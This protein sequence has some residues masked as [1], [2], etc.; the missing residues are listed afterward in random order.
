MKRILE[1]VGPRRTDFLLALFCGVFLFLLEKKLPIAR[2]DW[3]VFDKFT[4]LTPSLRPLDPSLAIVAIDDYSIDLLDKSN[5]SWPWP[6]GAYADMIAYLKMAG[7]REIWIDM[8]LY[9]KDSDSLQDD[10]LRAVAMAAQNV[11]FGQ[12]KDSAGSVSIFKP[13]FDVSLPESDNAN[14]VI[15]YDNGGERLLA[16]PRPF[17]ELIRPPASCVTSAA[18]VVS[19][20]HKLLKILPPD[21]R[22]D[23]EK[24]ARLWKNVNY[25]LQSDPFRDKIVYIGATAQSTNDIKHFPVGGNEPGVMIHVVTRSNKLQN[26]FFSRE[27]YLVARIACGGLLFISKRTVHK[28][29]KFLSVYRLGAGYGGG[30]GSGFVWTV[31]RSNLVW[32]D[33]L[34]PIDCDNLYRGHLNQ[35]PER[36]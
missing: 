35:L 9:T 14:P 8:V 28:V 2:S 10:E 22:T 3:V 33:A 1:F 20:G 4:Q 23:S 31:Y 18:F 34:Y 25:P 24:V 27:S 13:T 7:A 16:W 6:R 21:D 12:G 17:S 36:G 26:G 11:H 19:E 32:S 30:N 15:H 5:W 29:G